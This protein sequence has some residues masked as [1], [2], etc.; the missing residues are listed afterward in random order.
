MARGFA[1]REGVDY[2]DTFIPVVRYESVRMLLAIVAEKDYE[3]AQFD[4]KTAFLYGTLSER[5]FMGQP[6]GFED[7]SNPKAVCRLHKSIY[8]LKQSPSYWN[9]KFVEFPKRFN[10]NQTESDYCI[11]G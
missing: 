5:I 6:R 10:F 4:V 9:S 1:Q 11:F 3:I 8:G 2:S 7:K